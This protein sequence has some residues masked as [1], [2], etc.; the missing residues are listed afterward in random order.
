MENKAKEDMLLKS[1]NKS[2]GIYQSSTTQKNAN[3]NMS[4][5]P[6]VSNLMNSIN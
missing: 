3:S 6:H 4:L 5:N 2:P 1:G